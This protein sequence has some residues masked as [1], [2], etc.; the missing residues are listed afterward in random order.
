VL[1]LLA[2]SS[3]ALAADFSNRFVAAP[4]AP[5]AD[6]LYDWT[7]GYIGVNLGYGW[8][9]V[10]NLGARPSGAE[11][12]LQAGYNWQAGQ[13]VL[14]GETDIQLSSASDRF[15][16]WQF[17]NPWFG[18]L[19][20]RAGFAVNNVLF[21]ATAGLAYGE[22]RAR[23]AGLS[24]SKQHIGFT[25]GAGMEFGLTR[26]LSARAEYVFMNLSDRGYVLTGTSNGLDANKLRLGVNYRF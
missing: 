22:L 16:G 3:P 17:S 10:T 26:N 7:G 24:E 8:A 9:Q 11:G 25:A 21:Y 18:S 19:R 1:A 14:G 20:G 4:A 15:A 2:A 6:A 13:L 12:G 5:A 23:L